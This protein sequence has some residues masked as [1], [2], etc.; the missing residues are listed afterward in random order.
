MGG[1]A[2]DA[3]AEYIVA[4]MLEVLKKRTLT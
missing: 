3:S 1:Q 2:A 4:K